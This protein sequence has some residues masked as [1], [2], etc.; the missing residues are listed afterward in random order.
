MQLLGYLALALTIL[1]LGIWALVVWWIM[2]RE[3][4]PPLVHGRL[5]VSSRGMKMVWTLILLLAF[6]SGGPT[7]ARRAQS[8]LPFSISQPQ[9]SELSDLGRRLIT[10]DRRLRTGGGSSI[11]MGPYGR[12]DYSWQLQD[13]ETYSYSAIE[14]RFPLNFLIALFIFWLVAVRTPTGVEAEERLVLP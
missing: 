2:R 8:N 5:K 9:F 14:M 11:R 4:F 13:G 7:M 3:E 6:T 12:A 10:S 1:T